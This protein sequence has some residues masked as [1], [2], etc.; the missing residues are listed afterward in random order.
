MLPAT[1]L[2]YSK[3]LEVLEDSPLIY[4][5]VNLTKVPE[6]AVNSLQVSPELEES[7]MGIRFTM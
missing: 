4:Y 2:V 3:L 5:R 6:G 7:M 1:F